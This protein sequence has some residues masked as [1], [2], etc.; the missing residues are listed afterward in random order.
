[1]NKQFKDL[2]KNYHARMPIESISINPNFNTPKD[3]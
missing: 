3:W 2:Q 1:M